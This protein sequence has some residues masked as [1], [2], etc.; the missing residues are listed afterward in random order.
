VWAAKENQKAKGKCQKAK[1]K[2]KVKVKS[3]PCKNLCQRNRRG[4]VGIFIP[5]P[6]EGEGGLISNLLPGEKV[7]R[8]E[9]DEGFLS[10]KPRLSMRPKMFVKKTRTHGIALQRGGAATQE[11]FHHR[12][13]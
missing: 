1:V 9:A 11:G 8:Y 12:F 4:V 5:R 7:L 2:V 10:L 13:P 3:R 6:F